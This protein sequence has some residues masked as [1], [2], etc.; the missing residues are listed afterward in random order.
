MCVTERPQRW[1]NQT[2]FGGTE[3]KVPVN[4][5]E[6]NVSGWKSWLEHALDATPVHMARESIM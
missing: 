4:N 1:Y 6:K 5:K 3:A 2:G